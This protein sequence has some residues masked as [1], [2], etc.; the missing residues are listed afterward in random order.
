MLSTC[1]SHFVNLLSIRQFVAA[2]VSC[3]FKDGQV[4]FSKEGRLFG[5]GPMVNNLFLLEVEFLKPPTLTTSKEEIVLFTKV[6]KTLDLWHNRMGHPGEPA[7]R[8]LLKSMTGASFPPEKSLT[9]KAITTS[10]HSCSVL[11]RV[12]VEFLTKSFN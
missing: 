12:I 8:A 6:P 7:T 1:L 9:V 3:T 11:G 4:V 5:Y 2:K 10:L